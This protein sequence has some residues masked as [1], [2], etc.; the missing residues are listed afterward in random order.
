MVSGEKNSFGILEL[1]KK[2]NV[3][4]GH[5]LGRCYVKFG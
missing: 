1:F 5:K 4:K 3:N 2:I